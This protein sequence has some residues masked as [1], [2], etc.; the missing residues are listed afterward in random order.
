M[1][2]DM[3]SKA[4][5]HTLKEIEIPNIVT[6]IE[7]N[8]E[9]I[10]KSHDSIH[11]FIYLAPLCLPSTTEVSWH[12][13][14]AFL[15][16]HFE[17]FYQAHRS[18][19]DALSGY[20]NAGYTLLRNV[21]ELLVKGAFWECLAHKEFRDKL[22]KS[23]TMKGKKT[24]KGWIN[25]LIK[26]RPDIEDEL[27]ETSL[28]IFDK[29]AIIFEDPKF[30]KEFIYLPNLREIVEQLTDWNIF[31]PIQDP[32]ELVHKKIYKELSADVHVIPDKTDIGRRL[33]SQKKSFRD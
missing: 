21:L 30:R 19:L 24:L 32:V 25:D 18:F 10:R 5:S 2:K 12:Q 8:F 15:T 11:E 33:L 29:T 1:S 31:D 22:E 27:E 4:L 28:A 9:E 6:S 26:Q 14:S 13:K 3:L 17:A 7:I 20:Y 16:Y 23:E